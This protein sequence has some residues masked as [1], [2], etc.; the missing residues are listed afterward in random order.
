VPVLYDLS[1]VKP[2]S[3][4]N[5]HGCAFT[6]AAADAGNAD[7]AN[8]VGLGAVAACTHA[9]SLGSL[10]RAIE[11]RFGDR[12]GALNVRL[13]AEGSRLVCAP[14]PRQAGT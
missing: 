5:F 13:L 12:A 3:G 2:R 9:V 7:S 11:Q 4:A 14:W 10:E 1:L 6:Q 8:I